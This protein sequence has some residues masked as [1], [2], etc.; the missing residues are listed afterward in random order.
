VCWVEQRGIGPLHVQQVADLVWEAV[1][2]G[3]PTIDQ[4][5]LF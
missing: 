4:L 2:L 3:V 1:K 5:A